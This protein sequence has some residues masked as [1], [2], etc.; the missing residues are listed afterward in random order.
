MVDKR[1]V[2]NFYYSDSKKLKIRLKTWEKYG[3]N[4]NSFVNWVLGI[5]DIKGMSHLKFLDVGCGTGDFLYAVSKL[6]KNFEIYGL[7]ISRSMISNS[8]KKNFKFKKNFTVGDAEKIPFNS[9]FFDYLISIHTLHHVPDIN[10]AIS[11]FC[12]VVKTDGSIIVVTG[13]YDLDSGLNKLHYESLKQL[14]FPKFMLEKESYLR[15][16]GSRALKY[17]KNLGFP[18]ER[19]YYSNDL[20]FKS[21]KPVLEYYKSAMMYR[22]STGIND[23]RINRSQWQD[24]AEEMERRIIEIIKRDG[25]FIA[26]GEVSAYKLLKKT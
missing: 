24:L 7:D 26:P 22:N 15:F 14:N 3:T 11:E 6:N 19:F 16:S 12:R 4:K 9:D 23:I 8:R 21:V 13:N 1:V 10:K 17:F 2:K 20:H 5:L 25:L 18:F